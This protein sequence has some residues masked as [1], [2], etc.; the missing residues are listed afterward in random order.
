MSRRSGRPHEKGPKS[1]A[2]T[3]LPPVVRAPVTAPPAPAASA[4]GLD[5]RAIREAARKR[6]RLRSPSKGTFS[7]PAIPGKV[8][9]FAEQLLGVFAAIERPFGDRDRAAFRAALRQ[10]LERGFA[11]S[12][13]AR[14]QVTFNTHP[15]R[16]DVIQWKVERLL[17][18]PEDRYRIDADAEPTGP[19][20]LGQV[21]DA[22]L[23][24]LAKELGAPRDVSYLDVGAAIGRNTLPLARLGHPTDAIETIG[25]VA[26]VL[27]ELVGAEGLD[28][29]VVRGDFWDRE[30]PLPRAHYRLV[31]FSEIGDRLRGL[32]P[33]RALF[34]RLAEVLEPGGM[35][36][37]HVFVARDGYLPDPVTRELAETVSCPLYTREELEDAAF[38]LPL[39]LVS[40]E[41]ALAYERRY[42][43]EWPP[44]PWYAAW[45]GGRTVFD[46]PEAEA[47]PVELRWLVYERIEVPAE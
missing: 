36:L 12:P 31:C 25:A 34:R 5:E 14:V 30:V 15:T 9:A 6:L 38:G 33:V 18:A 2:G 21:P 10:W 3:P 22:R 43:A 29:H 27:V 46:L 37:L 20:L 41:S 42:R 28:V 13:H 44:A 39:A 16:H 40:D 4:L 19:P 45:A 11:A 35:A 24:M 7:F 1:R 47:A 26:D 23:L 8:D 32:T 17:P